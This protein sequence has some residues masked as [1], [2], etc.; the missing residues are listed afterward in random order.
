VT[1]GELSEAVIDALAARGDG[2]PLYLEGVNQREFKKKCF[3]KVNGRLYNESG[4]R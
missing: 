1:E 2:M 3:L 4:K